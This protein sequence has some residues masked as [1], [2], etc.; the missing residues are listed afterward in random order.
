METFCFEIG[1]TNRRPILVDE[2]VSTVVVQSTSL[3]EGRELSCQ[4]VGCRSEMVTSCKL[5]WVEV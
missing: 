1:W 4:L 2:F 3:Q 5:L